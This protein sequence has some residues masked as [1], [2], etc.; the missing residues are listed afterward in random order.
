MSSVHTTLA[1]QPAAT[2]PSV[3]AG[4]T[5]DPGTFEPCTGVVEARFASEAELPVLTAFH[6]ELNKQ[7]R[8]V[9]IGG[10]RTEVFATMPGWKFGD[11]WHFAQSFVPIVEPKA[12]KTIIHLGPLVAERPHEVTWYYQVSYMFTHEGDQRVEQWSK[13]RA[14]VQNKITWTKHMVEPGCFLKVRS[15]YTDGLTYGPWSLP[16]VKFTVP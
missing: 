9:V 6:E 14:Q 8:S 15:R 3:V 2:D 12:D 1:R 10:I 13:P 7:A 4:A 5:T 16:S 11:F